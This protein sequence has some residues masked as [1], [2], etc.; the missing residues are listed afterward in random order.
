M[1]DVEQKAEEARLAE[2]ARVKE[3]QDAAEKL[4][5]EEAEANA[6]FESG[7]TGKPIE[8]TGDA[9]PAGEIEEE[10]E[11][12]EVKPAP[13]VELPKLAQITEV[14]FQ[15]LMANAKTVEDVK[16][17]MEKRFNDAFGKMGGLE[18]TLKQIQDATPVGQAI[19]VSD[20]DLAE[21]KTEFP[22]LTANLAKGLTRVLGKMKGTAPAPT[23]DPAS[24][25]ERVNSLVEAR[26]SQEREATLK[27][28]AVERL[29]D[30]H[31]NWREIIGPK[32]STT[33]YR[34]WLAAQDPVYQAT[35]LDSWD[36]RV[37]SKSIDAFHTFEKEKQKKKPASPKPNGSDA[38]NQRLAE[39][40]LPKGNAAP[41]KPQ[42]LTAEE[43]F[44]AG[45][46]SGR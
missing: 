44:E 35:V 15:S 23:F 12:P 43:E 20:E 5:K 25:D 28:V 26:V 17:A 21:L 42:Q 2:E 39:A 40:V 24:I 10:P 6:A 36:A 19:S 41:S 29:T 16:S 33:P 1:T 45:F 9:T 34:Q 22:D 30:R 46:K 8:P 7:F 37:I 13:V 18:R 27:A 38:R 3:E 11:K 31:E 14:Q 4:A 32:D